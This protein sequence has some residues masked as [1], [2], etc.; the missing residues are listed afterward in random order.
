MALKLSDVKDGMTKCK[1]S[2]NAWPFIVK[3]F[4]S[5][6]PSQKSNTKVLK[7][8]TSNSNSNNETNIDK[9]RNFIMTGSD[10]DILEIRDIIDKRF[11]RP[12]YISA[13]QE[14]MEGFSD[15]EDL[16]IAD[17]S[18]PVLSNS[19]PKPSP[20]EMLNI[21]FDIIESLEVVFDRKTNYGDGIFDIVD[22]NE[23]EKLSR[24][25]ALC[26]K[27]GVKFPFNKSGKE[28]LIIKKASEY[29]DGQKIKINVKFSKWGPF[30]DSYGY[31]CYVNRF[32]FK[33]K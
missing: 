2:K 9:V 10:R 15:D 31:S 17:G 1:S 18:L 5:L 8:P 20:F 6:D 4:Y 14:M 12:K 22:A 7:S 24:A 33:K 13:T 3:H 16:G 30:N 26:Q 28:Q 23:R 29:S 32:N 19:L 21:G 11:P 25:S 27:S